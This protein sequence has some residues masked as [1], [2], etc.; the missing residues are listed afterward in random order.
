M[1]ES[2]EATDLAARLRRLADDL[3][4][5][6]EDIVR[7]GEHGDMADTGHYLVGCGECARAWAD[8][9]DKPKHECLAES[10]A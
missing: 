4:D 2:I 3:V 8:V 10:D 1:A 9:I 5:V 6:G 7:V